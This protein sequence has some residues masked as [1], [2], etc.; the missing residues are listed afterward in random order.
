MSLL[1]IET[2]TK[3]AAP[4][5]YLGFSLQQLRACFHLF[6]AADGDIVSL[7]HLDDV[8]V[9][10]AD[11]TLLL[12][13]DKSTLSGNPAADRS[14]D[15]WK[16]FANWATLCTEESVNPSNTDFHLFV[17]PLKTGAIVSEMH[18]AVTTAA[19][20]A[21]LSKIEK[22]IDPKNP[23]AGCAPHVRKFLD[24][25]PGVCAAIIK[26]FA[27]LSQNDAVEG[28]R[29]FVRAGLPSA[30][31]NDMT[32]AAIGIARDRYDRLIRDAQTPKIDAVVFRRQFQAFTR[33][34]NLAGYLVS[35]GP[36][37]A[38]ALVAM[39]LSEAP[40]FVRQLQAVEATSDLLTMAVSDYLRT[41]A[42][43]V[44][45]AAEGLVVAESF[46]D[47][48]GQ[49]LRQHGLVRDEVEEEKCHLNEA[50]R[51]RAVYRQCSKVQLPL[52]G[53]TLPSH[54]IAGAYNDL[55]EGLRLGWHPSYASL[56]KGGAQ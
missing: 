31:V 20:T 1:E 13:Q 56:F 43:K 11:G 37:P 4:G 27:L 14:I 16:T 42:D 47:L 33:R 49:L 35:K 46:D 40:T 7:E 22:L 34:A 26:Q 15:L 45:W 55:A 3:T 39:V 10:R 41:T 24:A 9:H 30:A 25:K 54:F 32:A 18:A 48:D 36:N 2:P 21:V 8:A 29:Q 6:S 17:T 51:G 38:D 5:Q 28:V 53:Q 12:E 19:C 44:E 50:G 23:E 52:D